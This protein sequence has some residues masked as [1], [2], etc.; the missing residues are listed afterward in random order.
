[1]PEPRIVPPD[2]ARAKLDDWER[3]PWVRI[4]PGRL[5][6]TSPTLPPCSVS[7]GRRRWPCM[8]RFPHPHRG[9]AICGR[10][11]EIYPCP[12]ARALGVTDA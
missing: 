1:M 8:G 6:M 9:N 11:F 3:T 10:C 12:T 2:E 4:V 7:S 5:G